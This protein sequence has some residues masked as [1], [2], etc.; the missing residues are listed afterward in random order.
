MSRSRTRL[1]G[2]GLTAGALSAALLVAPQ[3]A[4][5]VPTTVGPSIVPAG[6]NANINDP[7]APFVAVTP[8]VQISTTTGCAPKLAAAAVGGPW[9]VTS[10]TKNSNSSV[11]FTL[12]A[13]PASAPNGAVKLHTVCV[14]DGAV[15]TS[16]NLYVGGS[17]YVGQP[18]SSAVS[19]GLSGGGNQFAVT[20]A[21]GSPVFTAFSNI[22]AVFSTA[23]CNNAYG[24]TNTANQTV[25]NV[26]K[27]SGSSVNL[28]VPPGVTAAGPGPTM[29]NVCLF[30]S[31]SAT[32][33]LI[34]FLPYTVH[35]VGLSPAGGSY[36]TSNGA[37][38]SS[39]QPFLS[40]VTTPAVLLLS[41][42][43]SCPMAYS[44][45]PIG[46]VTPIVLNSPGA[47]RRLTNF[48]AALTI[49]PLL[50]AQPNNQP[51]PYQVCF[52]SNNTTGGLLGTAGY[53]A[54]VV[55]MPTGVI[56]SAG[57]AAG[58]NT[59]TVVGN[60][61]PL[62]PGKITATLGGAPLTNIQ[63]MGDKAFTAQVPA[64]AVEDNVALVVTT[65]AGTKSLQGAYSFLNPIKIVPN[66]A[67]NTAPF[68][69]VDVQGMGFF[70]V[71]FGSSGNAGRVF[72]VDGVYNGDDAGAGVRANGPVAECV[73]V[74]PISDDE[75]ICT[76]QLDRR[77]NAT[78][79]AFFDSVGYTNPIT[80]ISTEAGSKI[81]ASVGKKFVTNDIGQPI[82]QVSNTNIPANSII[83][84]ILSAE[85]A[86]ISAPAV[87]TGSTITVAIGAAAAHSQAN[88]LMTTIGSVTVTVAPG[89]GAFTSADIGR[90]FS[91][92]AGITPGTTIVSVA[93]GGAS[94]SLSAPAILNTEGTIAGVSITGGTTAL[95]GV[96]IAV[97]DRYGVIGANTLGIP[98]GTTITAASV[99]S[100]TLSAPATVGGG[101]VTLTVNRPVT[102]ALYAAAPVMKGSYHLTVVS[103]GAPDAELAD[104]DYWQTA[105]TSS[106]VFTVAAF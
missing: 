45:A 99:G 96:N 46:G 42:G 15:A 26:P 32:G 62:E 54:A 51:N 22:A 36:L 7:A 41:S 25:P 2:A 47:V 28:V 19:S 20:A 104:P 74:L 48:R 57:P 52:Y 75:L 106:S 6:G 88:A 1:L 60:D 39:L 55:A 50:L 102:G 70:G 68:V 80:D 53:T 95:T 4:F 34:T 27:Q 93:P 8:T 58:G 78:G 90:V 17:I 105:V 79:S 40:G 81:I 98:V 11:S 43:A 18:V 97:G 73:N 13:G 14:Y 30:D 76:L 31:S 12:P 101:P 91:S 77:L 94:A 89:A 44:A 92:T 67:P 100:A 37:T 16:S 3:A 5:A 10:L 69:D 86:V 24:A 56:P 87:A 49:P 82:V 38:A 63:P 33:T 29:Y 21:M 65:P 66:T 84:S 23:P 83:T 61:F 72:L 64:H 71:N 9:N 35:T 85:K 59:I 103:N